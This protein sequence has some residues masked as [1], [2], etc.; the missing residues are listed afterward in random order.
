VLDSELRQGDFFL[1]ADRQAV[2]N[3]MIVIPLH[4]MCRPARFRGAARF[5]RTFLRGQASTEQGS[6]SGGR[7]QSC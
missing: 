3:R 4:L 5:D 2:G 1:I 7:S 6:H